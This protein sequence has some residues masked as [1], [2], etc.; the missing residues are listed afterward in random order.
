MATYLITGVSRGIG[1]GLLSNLSSNPE[2]TVIGLA[3]NQTAT[4]QKVSS[5]LGARRNVHILQADM[6]DYESILRA[7]RE[8][9][10]I[11]GS[12]DYIIA[13]AG[14]MSPAE[15][16]ANI[17]ELAQDPKVF[18][19]AFA[20]TMNTN[21]I[22]N[23]HL[24]TSLMPLVLKG[25]AKKIIAI[26]SASADI[27]LQRKYDLEL[28]PTYSA[29]KAALNAIVA[30]FSAQYARDGVLIMS[31]CPGMVDTQTFDGSKLVRSDTVTIEFKLIIW[32]TATDAQKQRFGVFLQSLQRYAPHFTGPKT[33]ESAVKDLLAVVGKSSVENGDGG[34]FARSTEE[35]IPTPTLDSTRA[36]HIIAK[37]TGVAIR[38]LVDDTSFPDAGVDYLLSLV[39]RLGNMLRG[40]KK[41]SNPYLSNVSR[42]WHLQ[43]SE[44]VTKTFVKWLFGDTPNFTASNSLSHLQPDCSIEILPSSVSKIISKQDTK[45]RNLSMSGNTYHID[46]GGHSLVNIGDSYHSGTKNREALLNLLLPS[47]KSSGSLDLSWDHLQAKKKRIVD[48]TGEWILDSGAFK[49]WRLEPGSFLWLHGI[50]GCGKTVL[51][52]IIIDHLRDSSTGNSRTAGYYFNAREDEKRNVSRLLRS[53]IL[54]LCPAEGVLPAKVN[55]LHDRSL[56]QDFPDDLLLD[57]LEYLI[58]RQEQTYIVIDALDEC[59]MS[60]RVGEEAEP[61]KLAKLILRLTS[62]EAANLHLLVTSRDGGLVGDLDFGLRNIVQKSMTENPHHLELNLQ[63]GKANDKIKADIKI[64]VESEL[65]RWNKRKGKLWLPL[66][67]TRW[68]QVANA[69]KQRADG[70][71]RLAACLLDLLWRKS[72]WRELELAL[73]DLPPE[74]PEVYDRIFQDIKNQGQME[75]ARILV[76][77]LLYSERPLR[78]EELTEVTMADAQGD[79][80]KVER[81]AQDESYVSSTLSSFIIIS[82]DYLVQFAHQTVKNYLLLD[83]TEGGFFTKKEESQIFLANCCLAYM[84]FCDRFDPERKPTYCRRWQR[85]LEAYV[86]LEYV[87]NK[88]FYNTTDHH[89]GHTP[90]LEAATLYDAKTNWSMAGRSLFRIDDNSEAEDSP[91]SLSEWAASLKAW[92][93]QVPNIEFVPYYNTTKYLACKGY[94]RFVELLLAIPPDEDLHKEFDEEFDADSYFGPRALA[95]A[96]LGH[97]KL[98]VQL[99]L[100]DTVKEMYN[101]SSWWPENQDKGAD[102]RA[103]DNVGWTALDLAVRNAVM[104]FNPQHDRVEH[105]YGNIDMHNDTETPPPVV[106]SNNKTIA[107]TLRLLSERAASLDYSKQFGWKDMEIAPTVVMSNHETAARAA[108]LLPG[109]EPDLEDCGT[110]TLQAASADI[111]VMTRWGETTTFFTTTQITSF[112]ADGEP[113]TFSWEERVDLLG[114]IENPGENVLITV[115]TTALHLAARHGHEALA[116]LL[117]EKEADPN[118]RSRPEDED[119]QLG[120]ERLTSHGWTALHEAASAGHEAIF[121]LLLENGADVDIKDDL[122]RT[123]L[124]IAT[125]AGT[126]ENC[127]T[128]LGR[129]RVRET[130][131]VVD[132][133]WGG[134]KVPRFSE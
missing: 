88:W 17:G 6:A 7:A 75:T 98:M 24:F 23:V 52:S 40:Y 9:E 20:Y 122:G 44:D 128:T 95:A 8:T 34:S 63:D 12:L 61:E 74:L 3:R 83:T 72:Q 127:N 130:D 91:Q 86:L 59:D 37:E 89:H 67:E 99:M 85:Y 116:R 21:V 27:E 121:K 134:D 16:F 123:A 81:G 38:E 33:T 50:A 76:R 126:N 73:D 129:K 25:K 131:D 119:L 5:E 65:D 26:S 1:Y 4:E 96:L 48:K 69:V 19:E 70:M 103:R 68:N 2:N 90:S 80:F 79:S 120:G 84:Q 104:S 30:K 29:S 77:W 106:I 102:I 47:W 58:R 112:I 43:A 105:I 28:S 87:F 101:G 41:I 110:E 92:L 124:Q 56:S 53:L 117:L 78:L 10:K 132:G 114:V 57:T 42:I 60:H 97:Y 18:D 31:I 51:S 49:P 14:V 54:Q 11:T 13:N 39:I 100:D 32:A 82:E 109:K 45:T 94:E 64:F 62:I 15:A 113:V 125:F 133:R 108:H 118:A 115:N 36:L 93:K 66:N 71:F 55:E 111:C 22:G 35:A 46:A 107:R